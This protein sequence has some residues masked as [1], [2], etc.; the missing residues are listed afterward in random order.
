MARK[1]S[2]ITEKQEKFVEAKLAGAP[3]PEAADTSAP[4]GDVVDLMAA[5]KA[6]VEAAKQRREQAAETKAS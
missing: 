1:L 4:A 5:L 6:S 3:A 2:A